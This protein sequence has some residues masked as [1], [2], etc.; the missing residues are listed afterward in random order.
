ML[1]NLVKNA[2]EASPKNRTVSIKVYN[3]DK[4]V[5]II[6]NFGAIPK[7]IRLHFFEKYITSKKYGGNGLGT[8]SSKLIADLLKIKLSFDTDEKKGTFIKVDFGEVLV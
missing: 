2:V 8:Y 7:E 5:I 1:S 4:F 6:H 3:E